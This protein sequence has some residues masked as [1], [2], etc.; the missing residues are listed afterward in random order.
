MARHPVV[1]TARVALD[2]QQAEQQHKRG[3][4]TTQGGVWI[5]IPVDDIGISTHE[6]LNQDMWRQDKQGRVF[7]KGARMTAPESK[8]Q[9]KILEFLRDNVNEGIPS[10]YYR[11]V[12]GH[13]LHVSTYAN[14]YAKHFH[15]GWANPF[16]P[17]KIDQPLD[18]SYSH[19][20]DMGDDCPIK[21]MYALPMFGFVEDVGWISG[22]K[23]TDVFVNVEVGALVD[24]AGSGEA[25]EFNDFNE[26]EVGTASTAEN[27]DD[28]TLGTSSGIALVAG[29]QVDDGG[30][31]PT[32]T[33]VATIT[34]DA[35]ES[36]EEHG[37]F[38]TTTDSLMDRSLTGGQSVASSDQV[39]Y[40]Y[41]LTV[42]PEA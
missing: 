31:P 25:A 32:M 4:Y 28:T 27:N 7:R 39:Q 14:L 16:N 20:C 41:V 6:F 22:A 12:L 33:T 34:A 3:Q 5:P 11:A 19:D 13:D 24:S 42:N 15:S 18:T 36:W 35:T 40:T 1:P 8:W 17:D 38:S 21:K 10:A 26:H 9:R 2:E 30:D 29:T 37:V 23:V